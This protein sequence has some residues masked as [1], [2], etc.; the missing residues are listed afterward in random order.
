[1]AKPKA[2]QETESGLWRYAFKF[3]AQLKPLCKPKAKPH[4][5]EGGAESEAEGRV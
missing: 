1:M 4:E 3:P 2:E 5:A